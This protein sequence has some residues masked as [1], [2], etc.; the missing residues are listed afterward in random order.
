MADNI[1]IGIIFCY[2][3]PTERENEASRKL[4]TN[5]DIKKIESPNNDSNKKNHQSKSELHKEDK[6]SVVEIEQEDVLE[7]SHALSKDDHESN[8]QQLLKDI[9]LIDIKA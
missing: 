1:F 4:G 6:K 5:M 3:S 2:T 7:L 8:G 9:P